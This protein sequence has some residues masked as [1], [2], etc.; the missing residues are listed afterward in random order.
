MQRKVFLFVLAASM[1]TLSSCGEPKTQSTVKPTE[2]SESTSGQT[3]KEPSSESDS[4][5][6]S[7]DVSS[8]KSESSK[9]SSSTS[10]VP[11][12]KNDI[13]S[14]T[15]SGEREIE[16][17]VAA[18]TKKGY[19]LDDGTG[20]IY[21]YVP[22]NAAYQLGDYVKI[23]GTVAPYYATWEVTSVESIAKVEGTAPALAAAKSL[24]PA[25]VE[26]W[27][28]KPGEKSE[29]TAALATK[30]IVPLTLTATAKL[31]IDGYIMLPIEGSSVMLEPSNVPDSMAFKA[32]IE[33]T[34]NFYTNG[35]N[36]S[37]KYVSLL[38]SSAIANYKA[39]ES[40]S[41]SGGQE[42]TVGSKLSLTATIA[43]VGANPSVQWSTDKE[44]VATIDEKGVV[45]GM[46]VGS[47]NITAK[48]VGDESKTA[49]YA[50]TVKE[51]VPTKSLAKYDFSN[52]PSGEDDTK[53]YGA[54]DAAGVLAIF[55]NKEYLATGTNVVTAVKTATNAYRSNATQGPKIKGLKLGA[56]SGKK[57]KLVLTASAP[58]AGVTLTARAFATKSTKL[59]SISVNGSSAVALTADDYAKDRVIEFT[60][61]SASEITIDTSMYCVFTALELIGA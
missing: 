47:A 33:Y 13:A 46:A 37:K 54:I 5:A 28:S 20:A 21:V 1:L 51:A 11:T 9:D 60:F 22:L 44:D 59:A 30:D 31:S 36:A 24:T 61:A 6:T 43:P 4:A 26:D 15:A 53:T 3:S 39:V 17:V 27:V 42:V 12:P 23:K 34:V 19:V 14:I 8:S 52:I 41:I 58:V 50:I 29:E 56:A 38:V 18:V 35:Y 55:A 40:V 57:G 25:M 2:V 7:Q 32:G 45:T 49:T 16:G 10:S 48:A